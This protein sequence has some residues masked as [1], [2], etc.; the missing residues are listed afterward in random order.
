[1]SPLTIISSLFSNI[2]KNNINDN[3]WKTVS[4][5]AIPALLIVGVYY[6][7][8][9]NKSK[10]EL[11]VSKSTIRD[12][13]GQKELLLLQNSNLKIKDT[14]ETLFSTT[15]PNLGLH[16]ELVPPPLTRTVSAPN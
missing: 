2:L 1:M 7:N 11:S 14:C 10:K 13:E 12:L 16:T 15:I 5:V 9:A 3:P 8:S 4:F 6:A